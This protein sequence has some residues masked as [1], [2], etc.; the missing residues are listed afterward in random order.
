MIFLNRCYYYYYYY[1]YYFHYDNYYNFDYYHYYYYYYYHY[2]YFHYDYYY[3][4][5]YYLGF[6]LILVLIIFIIIGYYFFF[7]NCKYITTLLFLIILYLICPVVRG[8]SAIFIVFD[9][10]PFPFHFTW[11]IIFDSSS[12]LIFCLFLVS[13]FLVSTSLT[14][15]HHLPIRSP[16]SFIPGITSH[17]PYI[18]TPPSCFWHFYTYILLHF[19][20]SFFFFN[21]TE[22]SV[23]KL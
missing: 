1:Y 8:I 10:C 22:W 4:F 7:K 16:S 21:S 17:H 20:N 9:L 3:N 19:F 23:W 2:Y 6:H 12:V 14:D 5:D 11:N 13:Y 15:L 18:L